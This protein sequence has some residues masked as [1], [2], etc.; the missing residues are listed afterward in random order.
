MN[1]RYLQSSPEA[2]VDDRRPMSFGGEKVPLGITTN[3]QL[4]IVQIAPAS[5]ETSDSSIRSGKQR[6]IK[7]KDSMPLRHVNLPSYA[8]KTDFRKSSNYQAP[9]RQAGLTGQPIREITVETRR[10]AVTSLLLI[11][12]K[13][14]L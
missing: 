12:I 4:E 8:Q 1:E 3:G 11:S 7:K 5:Q 6:V 9:R 13:P 2:T 10:I 14:Q